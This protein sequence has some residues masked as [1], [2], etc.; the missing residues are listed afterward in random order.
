MKKFQLFNFKADY[1][2][3]L[4]FCFAWAYCL[5]CITQYI[6]RVAFYLYTN[7]VFNDLEKKYQHINFKLHFR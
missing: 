6:N 4:F 1:K 5:K 7:S 2:K 3:A